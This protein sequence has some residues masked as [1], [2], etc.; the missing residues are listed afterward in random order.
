VRRLGDGYYYLAA[1]AWPENEQ[2][3]VLRD[4]WTPMS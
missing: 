1:M 3:L 4:S 2:R